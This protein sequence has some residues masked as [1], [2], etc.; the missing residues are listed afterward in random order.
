[1]S[2]TN[3]FHSSGKGHAIGGG[4]KLASVQRHNERGYFSFEYDS[5]K[6]H[7]LVGD[8]S[9]IVNDVTTYINEKFQPA[10]DDYNAWQKRRDRQ[11]TK[12]PFEY[13]CDN[14]NLDIANEVIFQLGDKEFWRA[15]RKERPITRNEKKHILKDFPDEVKEIM[16]DIFLKQAAA[17]E[18]IYETDGAK[19][20]N[21]ITAD[22]VFSQQTISSFFSDELQFFSKIAAKKEKERKKDL[23]KMPEEEKENFARYLSATTTIEFVEDKRLIQRIQNKDM[24][25]H[26]LN[27]TSHY[28]E[29][30][31]HAHGI[32]VCSVRGFEKGLN[33]RVAKSVVLN[34]WCLST[35]QDRMHEIAKEEMAKYPELFTV[36]LEDKLPGRNYDFSVSEYRNN[37]EKEKLAALTEQV[38]ETTELLERITPFTSEEEYKRAGAEAAAEIDEL[39]NLVQSFGDSI[40][41]H[42]DIYGAT[43]FSFKNL[44]WIWEK[45][46]L[47]RFS[48]LTQSL[49]EKLGNLSLYEKIKGVTEAVSE[50]LS[51]RLRN[52]YKR[53]EDFDSTYEPT[54]PQQEL[55]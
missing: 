13:F 55:E 44:K 34:K 6:I 48:E 32:S 14:K 20:I 45:E 5:N 43:E 36:P 38:K 1:M 52:A 9:S 54:V 25:I 41:E 18:K 35:I 26:L 4:G 24:E 40:Q 21:L 27:L 22:Y 49:R 3:T 46:F 10:V 39:E 23:E 7:S 47:P 11:I 28:D 19:I 30:S 15:T 29:Y 12:T 8:V 17:Y 42:E 16:D 53:S 51:A 31:P 50:A 33:E 37:K 2:M